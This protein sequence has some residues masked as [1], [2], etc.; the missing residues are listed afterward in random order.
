MLHA[1][2]VGLTTAKPTLWVRTGA[3]KSAS[4]ARFQP[5]TNLPFACRRW[6]AVDLTALDSKW[7]Q[8]W[9]ETR[10]LDKQ[11]GKSSDSNGSTQKSSYVLPMF[12]YP[13]GSLHIGHLRVYAIADIVAR[14]RSLKGDD[15][16]L[17]MGWDAF[18][19]PAEN[20]AL[21]RGLAP[22]GWT[23]SNIVKMKE[24]LDLMNGSWD[25]A[26]VSQLI[27]ISS[28]SGWFYCPHF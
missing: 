19:L 27:H 7:Q 4:I 21:E 10:R 26:K 22:D 20:A 14:Y 12:P 1:S 11:N 16:L 18:G 5:S 24:Q 9:S 15:V 8:V 17:P 23:K 28:L 25:W 2:R 3:T 13:S 6:Y